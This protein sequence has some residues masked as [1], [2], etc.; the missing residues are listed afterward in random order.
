MEL[1]SVNQGGPCG[2]LASIQA[3]ALQHL[4]FGESKIPTV[5]SLQPTSQDRSQC[6]ARALCDIVW[7]AGEKKHAIIA[8]YVSPNHESPGITHMKTLQSLH[9]WLSQK[10]I[11]DDLV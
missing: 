10:N 9:T 5:A 7:R 1:F 2:V 8:M 4:L 3:C 6:L 11:K